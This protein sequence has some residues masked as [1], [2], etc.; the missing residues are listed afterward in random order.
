MQTRSDD[1]GLEVAVGGGN[2]GFA[3]GQALQNRFGPPT[4]PYFRLSYTLSTRSERVAITTAQST[5]RYNL[6]GRSN[7]Q[8]VVLATGDVVTSGTVDGFSSYSATG[9]SVATRAA[10]RDAYERLSVILSDKIVA[11]LQATPGL[12]R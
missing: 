7:Y 1:P 5:N 11:R 2:Y 3:M 4:D 9:S 10:S 6:I 8:L 12:T